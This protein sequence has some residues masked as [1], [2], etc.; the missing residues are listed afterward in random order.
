MN[1]EALARQLLREFK[2]DIGSCLNSLREIKQGNLPG[3]NR[4]VLRNSLGW[5]VKKVAQLKRE[6]PSIHGPHGRQMRLPL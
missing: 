4:E 3:A 6:H 1:T 5:A 2:Q